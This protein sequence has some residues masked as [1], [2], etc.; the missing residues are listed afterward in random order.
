[1]Q[2]S[3]LCKDQSFLLSSDDPYLSAGNYFKFL[4]KFLEWTS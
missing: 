4:L 1:M 3:I 2:F